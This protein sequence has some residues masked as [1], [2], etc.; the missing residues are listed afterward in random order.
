MDDVLDVYIS[1][2][3]DPRESAF[4][5]STD[6][7]SPEPLSLGNPRARG[8]SCP[9]QMHTAGRQYYQSALQRYGSLR[10]HDEFA[11]MNASHIRD[12]LIEV[13]FPTLCTQ[14]GNLEKANQLYE[15][16]I[17]VVVLLREDEQAKSAIL[18]KFLD[19]LGSLVKITKS[20]NSLAPSESLSSLSESTTKSEE[21][22][23]FVNEEI[24]D[25]ERRY[26]RHLTTLQDVFIKASHAPPEGVRSI[27][28]SGAFPKIAEIQKVHIDLLAAFELAKT[29]GDFDVGLILHSFMPRFECY[30]KYLA[31]H[32]SAATKLK[33]LQLEIP[34][35]KKFIQAAE[36][37]PRCEKLNM[38]DFLIMPVQRLPRY[39]LLLKELLKQTP[40]SHEIYHNLEKAYVEIQQLNATMNAEMGAEKAFAAFV[41]LMHTIHD[42]PHDFLTPSRSFMGQFEA[43]EVEPTTSK[44]TRHVSILMFNDSIMVVKRK[45]SN[46]FSKSKKYE[47]HFD[48]VYDLNSL[49]LISLAD[50]GAENCFQIEAFT[51]AKKHGAIK[52]GEESTKKPKFGD[53]FRINTV[54]IDSA[55]S[56]AVEDEPIRVLRAFKITDSQRFLTMYRDII[57]ALLPLTHAPG[58]EIYRKWTNKN[59]DLV[60]HVYRNLED[61]QK[62]NQSQFVILY[63]QKAV[64]YRELLKNSHAK[65]I[66]LV[67]SKDSML[68]ACFHIKPELCAG[69]PKLLSADTTD[70]TKWWRRIDDG[71]VEL[72][73]KR[74]DGTSQCALQYDEAYQLHRKLEAHGQL[75]SIVKYYCESIAANSSSS[76]VR[77]ASVLQTFKGQSKAGSPRK[78][79]ARRGSLLSLDSADEDSDISIVSQHSAPEIDQVSPRSSTPSNFLEN[80]FATVTKGVRE[81]HRRRSSFSAATLAK[82]SPSKFLP[83]KQPSNKD[84]IVPA[85]LPYAESTLS[86]LRDLCSHIEEVGIDT[87]AIYER[88]ASKKFVDDMLKLIAQQPSNLRESLAVGASVHSATN[89]LMQ[90][91]NGLPRA[92]ICGNVATDCMNAI[93][94]QENVTASL[95]KIICNDLPASSYY[96]VS[97]IITHL[98]K[99][100]QHASVSFTSV[101]KLSACWAPLLLRSHYKHSSENITLQTQTLKELIEEYDK[102]FTGCLADDFRKRSNSRLS[103]SFEPEP[104]SLPPRRSVDSIAPSFSKNSGLDEGVHSM[105]P[106]T[107]FSLARSSSMLVPRPEEQPQNSPS[108]HNLQKRNSIDSIDRKVVRVPVNY[109]D[110]PKA[111]QLSARLTMSRRQPSSGIQR[112]KQSQGKSETEPSRRSVSMPVEDFNKLKLSMVNLC[113]NSQSLLE[114]ERSRMSS[115]IETLNR[116]IKNLK[117][118]LENE[119]RYK[120]SSKTV[121]ENDTSNRESPDNGWESL[122]Q[123]L[124]K[125]QGMYTAQ[126]SS[127][128]NQYTQFSKEISKIV[129]IHRQMEREANIA[130][131]RI[132]QL[133]DE[134][135][136]WQQEAADMMEELEHYKKI[137]HTLQVK[138][139]VLNDRD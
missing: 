30:R 117:Q 24:M 86:I 43:T 76:F 64:D 118:S 51:T 84:L 114:F 4:K 59:T 101:E 83:A 6:L 60:F 15:H 49:H 74:V 81:A 131:E 70:K 32:Q 66:G 13:P 98:R 103:V 108:S 17:D 28:I 99:V 123:E 129:E 97:I 55:V 62:T 87:D 41:Q 63:F 82:L 27:D 50:R 138:Q 22:L 45:S 137:A 72:F 106:V 122:N 20:T 136:A 14:L 61:Y 33:T 35:F 89:I 95:Q 85:P 102:I 104:P 37:D 77:T 90:W 100:L 7:L 2:L 125:V 126:M 54:A 26:V 25:T 3:R 38:Q 109:D 31:S 36:R 127:V 39:G 124:V 91:V 135:S 88:T 34:A 92:V 128:G 48:A 42:Y 46:T 139:Q 78:E 57:D 119:I 58:E 121:V 10:R 130:S 65:M 1:K 79:L 110:E 112:F 113:E 134:K 68:R 96:F 56:L 8:I 67:Q 40:Y 133:E 120:N 111:A 44:E 75:H 132:Q 105:K 19:S 29:D 80:K 116:T 107:P 115:E 16:N 21:R 73:F 9:D 69:R 93:K 71:F 18:P 52:L 47:L 53:L 23:A 5:D 12:Q 11:N 94:N